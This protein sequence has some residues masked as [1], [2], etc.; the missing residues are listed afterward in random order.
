MRLLPIPIN[1]LH[2]NPEEVTVCVLNWELLLEYL[3]VLFSWPPVAL[4]IA[5]FCLLRRRRPG[6]RYWPAPTRS[7]APF[8]EP[9]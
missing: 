8:P 1:P 2:L 4:V 9:P 5:I 6:R 3:K 7:P